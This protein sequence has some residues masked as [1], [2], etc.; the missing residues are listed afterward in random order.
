MVLFP[1]FS[2]GPNTGSLCQDPNPPGRHSLDP[3]CS[4]GPRRDRYFHKGPDD[5]DARRPRSSALSHVPVP[6]AK[7]RPRQ[8]PPARANDRRPNTLGAVSRRRLAGRRRRTMP[9]NMAEGVRIAVGGQACSAGFFS[10]AV[11][12]QA[13]IRPPG[14][15]RGALRKALTR[16]ARSGLLLHCSANEGRSKA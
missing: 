6:V 16:A 1:V 9:Q 5:S 13:R 14:G 8:C 12:N 10:L 3:Q 15:H 2:A 4:S 11:G 7:T